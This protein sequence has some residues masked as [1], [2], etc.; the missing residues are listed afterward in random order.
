V[1]VDAEVWP[2]DDGTLRSSVVLPKGSVYT[3]VSHRVPVTAETLRAQGDVG[4]MLT[5]AGR[6]AFAAY[7][8]VP[9]STAPA[10]TALADE[11]A[12]RATIGSVRTTYDVAI[13]Y[14]QWFRENIQYDLD[15][16]VPPDGVDAVDHFLFESRLGFCEQIASAFTIMLRTQGV[17]ARLVTGYVSGTRD[18]VSGVWEV[19]AS[20]AHAWVEVWFPET[21]WQAFDPTAAVPLAGETGTTT[22]GADLA[23]GLAEMVSTNRIA[24]AAAPTVAVVAWVAAVALRR[25]IYRRRRGRWGVLQDRFAAAA[26]RRGVAVEP[27]TNPALAREWSDLD[28]DRDDELRRLAAA[29][30]RAA[31]DPWWR[32]HDDEYD[33]ARR[34]LERI[35]A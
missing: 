27:P 20:E 31:F 12:D 10:T 25:S 13:T 19:R 22:I 2:Q 24:V 6:A 4:A 26:E 3:V 32:D 8:E 35:D 30:D 21:G 1:V 11:L 15:A 14:Q 18:E 23:R 16:P 29:L 9:P 34:L 28:P 5:A 7:L 17:P 33:T